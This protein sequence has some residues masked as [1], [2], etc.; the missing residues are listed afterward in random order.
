MTM[1][2]YSIKIS[3]ATAMTMM[4]MV[5]CL[6]ELD[7]TP[8]DDKVATA[9]DVYTDTESYKA[10]LAKLYATFAITGQIGP[11][12]DG[13]VKGVDE[14]FSNFIRSMWNMNELTTDE[15]VW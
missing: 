8:I 12:G 15:A 13:D 6:G 5:S 7:V 1:K 2:K 9:E 14:G 4:L 11:S 3:V 10:G